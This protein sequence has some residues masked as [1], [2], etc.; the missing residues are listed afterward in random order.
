MKK[1]LFLANLALLSL[2]AFAQTFQA[3]V[4]PA[5]APNGVDILLKAS[6][7]K[8]GKISSLTITIAIPVSV[9]TRPFI[10]SVDNTADPY[11]TYVIYD[12]VNQSIGGSMHY[13]YNV[14]GTGDVVSAGASIS[15]AANTN[16]S[17][18][19]IFF[20]G[21]PGLSSQIK[22]VNLPDGGT[23]PN[24]N[25]FFGLSIDGADVVALPSM[26]YAISGISTAVN[27]GLG[28][29]GT[30][31]AQTIGTV[32]LPIKF[33]QFN[34]VRENTSVALAWEVENETGLTDHYEIEKSTNGTDFKKIASV[35]AKSNGSFSNK[36]TMNDLI[37]SN[38]VAPATFYYRV[39]QVDADGQFV[40]SVVRTVQ[41]KNK[42]TAIG[43][44]PNP[45]KD[46]AN[47]I[48]DSEEQI[49]GWITL[50][51]VAGKVLLNNKIL[52][53]KGTNY[54]TI[55][56]SQF[57][58]GSYTVTVKTLSETKSGVLIKTRQ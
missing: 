41:L 9:G 58:A 55:N 27:D 38:G 16:F 56:M 53:V 49:D 3:T 42:G 33:L 31:F 20:G 1:Y 4:E 17:I 23:D 28:Y 21:A 30:N 2:T 46:I 5:G 25:S 8:T 52:L 6:A 22:M 37:I 18:A 48:I 26:F 39:K 51:D 57:A 15:F 12:A 50:T 45:V 13:I 40:Y 35:P 32:L 11:V 36:Y 7:I 54:K 14:L 43:V 24:P 10:S 47:V 34:A 29:S 19:K 44:Y